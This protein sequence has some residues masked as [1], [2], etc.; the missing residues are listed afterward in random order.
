[1][2]TVVTAH[3]DKAAAAAPEAA[4]PGLA[5]VFVVTADATTLACA[6]FVGATQAVTSRAFALQWLAAHYGLVCSGQDAHDW[7]RVLE[8]YET[9]GDIYYTLETVVS[10][11]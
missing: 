10:R 8:R 1:M 11:P 9:A 6:V 2:Q 3:P 4:G 7:E 5:T